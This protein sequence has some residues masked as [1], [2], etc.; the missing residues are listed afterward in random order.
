[1]TIEVL[2]KDEAFAAKI[3]EAKD[4]GEVAA[5]FQAQGFDTDED[6][7][8]KLLEFSSQGD[9]LSENALESVAGG[10]SGKWPWNRAQDMANKVEIAYWLARNLSRAW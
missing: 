5:L 7:L 6:A 1:M 8:K 10:I 9:E 3:R 2:M 4:F